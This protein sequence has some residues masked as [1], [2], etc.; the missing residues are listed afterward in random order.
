MKNIVNIEKI[1]YEGHGLG[2]IDDFIYFVPF[3]VCGDKIEIEIL[4]K[5]KILHG[6]K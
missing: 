5:K 4:N 6:L 1:I 3:S 2:K